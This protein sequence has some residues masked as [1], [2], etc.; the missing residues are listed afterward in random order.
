MNNAKKSGNVDCGSRKVE[1][2]LVSYN[3]YSFVA[4]VVVTRPLPFRRMGAWRKTLEPQKLGNSPG[5][6]PKV[7][8]RQRVAKESVAG[9]CRMR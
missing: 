4:V 7:V 5:S 9:Q 6:G 2:H 1:S 8:K 3:V